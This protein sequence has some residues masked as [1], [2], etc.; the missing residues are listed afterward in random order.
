M[1]YIESTTT[2]IMEEIMQVGNIESKM[3]LVAS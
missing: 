2:I 3:E 1:H